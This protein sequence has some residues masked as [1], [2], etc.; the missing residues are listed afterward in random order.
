MQSGSTT[1]QK[2]VVSSAIWARGPKRACDLLLS[3]LGV[4]LV[5]P[6][7]LTAMLLVKLTSP[8]P[9]FFVQVRTG[10]NDREFRPHKLRTMRGGRAPDSNEIV[11]LDHPD[12][13]PDYTITGIGR[14]RPTLP[15]QTREYNDFKRQRI[16]VRPRP[17]RPRPGQRQ[18]RDLLG[19]AHQ[20]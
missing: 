11:P 20:V 13:T 12:N 7:L 10:R 9:L 6:V 19:R 2:D 3:L 18:C 8:G 4:V 17:D 15:Q 5:S 16:L 14:T 1:E